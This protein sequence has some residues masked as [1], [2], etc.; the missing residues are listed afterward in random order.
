MTP[1]VSD[2]GGQ[3][4][5]RLVIQIAHQPGDLSRRGGVDRFGR[6][7]PGQRDGHG[8]EG[9]EDD[10]RDLPEQCEQWCDIIGQAE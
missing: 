3:R 9:V 2:Q 5:D 8:A 1:T 10:R 7:G 4:L 6:D